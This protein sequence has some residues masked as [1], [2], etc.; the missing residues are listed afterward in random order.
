MDSSADKSG[1]DGRVVRESTQPE[2]CPDLGW[3]NDDELEPGPAEA[4]AGEGTVAV[5]AISSIR[6]LDRWSVRGDRPS[7]LA[8]GSSIREFPRGGARYGSSGISA[9]AMRITMCLLRL[10]PSPSWRC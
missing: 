5:T 6:A 7:V 10:I 8:V 9:N 3:G 4:D 1:C 2:R